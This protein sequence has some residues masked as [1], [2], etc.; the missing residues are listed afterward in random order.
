M[1]W[2]RKRAVKL[3][4]LFFYIV[5]FRHGCSSI[6]F[7]LP[8]SSFVHYVYVHIWRHSIYCLTVS[9]CGK[10]EQVW[11]PSY[12][13]VHGGEHWNG[14]FLHWELFRKSGIS[15]AQLHSASRTN[16]AYSHFK[17]NHTSSILISQQQSYR[18]ESPV[19]SSYG[20]RASKSNPGCLVY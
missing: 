17:L 14:S 16:A 20:R 10:Q 11:L 1:S 12:L 5:F 13:P 18:P 15:Q 9:F 4:I 3:V 6:I 2:K 8:S 7:S 19:L